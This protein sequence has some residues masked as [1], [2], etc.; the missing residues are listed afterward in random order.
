MGYCGSSKATL[1]GAI[2]PLIT[3][4]GTAF[5]TYSENGAIK[6]FQSACSG[7]KNQASVAKYQ[8][9]RQWENAT[10]ERR[11]VWWT[12]SRLWTRSW[13][14]G[15][16]LILAIKFV[17]INAELMLAFLIKQTSRWNT[18]LT[19]TFTKDVMERFFQRI[20]NFRHVAFRFDKLADCFL[21]FVLLA[22]VAIHF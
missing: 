22:S 8:N 21:N 4:I 5:T 10:D 19:L 11:L 3:E 1:V 20:K 15:V 6:V 18:P 2:Y 16:E 9:S 12:Y 7:K 14:A 17:I 13:F